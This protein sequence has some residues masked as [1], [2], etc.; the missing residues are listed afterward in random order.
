MYKMFC[1]KKKNRNLNSD[2]EV[3][4]PTVLAEG[5]TVKD[6]NLYG[7]GGVTISGVFFGDVDIEGILIV[8]ESG[9]LKGDIKADDAYVYG[10]VEGNVSVK[11]KVH[12]HTEGRILGDVFSAS[13]IVEE[14]AAF[15][16]QCSTITAPSQAGANI[17]NVASTIF[18]QQTSAAPSGGETAQV[19]QSRTS[20]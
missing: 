16:G 2:T 15:R 11:G 8:S 17:L 19:A 5:V 12:I 7:G 14:G 1:D 10:A 13:L 3:K 20:P 6:G 4:T 18:K 9:N